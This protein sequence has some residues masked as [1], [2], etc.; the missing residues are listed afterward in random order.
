MIRASA[1]VD[2]S[3]SRIAIAE[4]GLSSS[5]VRSADTEFRLWLAAIVAGALVL[6]VFVLYQ[7]RHAYLNGGDGLTYSMEAIT[8]ARGS[9]FV[10]LAGRPDA[11]HPP[12]WTLVLTVWAWLGETSWWSQQVLACVIGSATVAAIGL[13]GRRIAGDRAG[14][15]AAGIAAL[16]GGL[17]RYERA[18]LS[19][20]LLLLEVAVILML[21]YRFRERPSPG[22]AAVLGA[23]GGVLA[24]THSE[25]ILILALLVAP[26]ILSA[27]QIRWRRRIGWLALAILSAL[28][29]IAP[30][31]IYNL[32]RFHHPVLLSNNFGY[33]MAQ[34]SCDASFYG[35]DPGQDNPFS[36]DFPGEITG[37]GQVGSWDLRCPGPVRGDETDTEAEYRSEAIT[38]TE[39]HL[40]RLPVVLLAREGRAFGF[41]DPLGQVV[42]D[43]QLEG[44]PRPLPSYAPT[45]LWIGRLSLFSYW[46]LLLPAAAGVVALRRRGVPVYPLFAFVITVVV[47]VAMTYG[48][49][50]SRASTEVPL[51]VLA[52]VGVDALL[53][54]FSSTPMLTMTSSPGAGDGAVLNG[55]AEDQP[56]GDRWDRR[57]TVPR[58]VPLAF[59]AVT[60]CAVGYLVDAMPWHTPPVAS[61]GTPAVVLKPSNGAVLNA[62]QQLDASVNNTSKVDRVEFRASGAHRANVLVGVG[63]ST[64]WGWVSS[65]DT[66]TFANGAY[67]LRAVAYG[68]NGRIAVS[69][70]VTVT[71]KH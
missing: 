31:T 13:A 58:V 42:V 25:Q 9:W 18:L 67:T 7:G 38:Y 36:S 68:R 47:A 65:W 35:T 6:R 3:K 10:G 27:K 23:L 15:V 11:L 59:V 50:R 33:A 22:Q 62:H 49:T 28:V 56:S 63:Y 16:Y 17:W 5:P 70:S 55:G 34:G 45:A 32:G 39:H 44:A 53:R 26:L 57:R 64:G 61:V 29:V 4:R 54:R 66:K 43:N 48:E 24:L 14:L 51:V 40:G 1:V 12:A 2:R 41:W 20:T 71:I 8:N 69:P 60:L 46:L 19:E 52:G 21:A 37:P 30:W